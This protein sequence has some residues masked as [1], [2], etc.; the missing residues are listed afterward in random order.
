MK[1]ELKQLSRWHALSKPEVSNFE[2]QNLYRKK[3]IPEEYEEL[4]NALTV[5][6][7]I[8]EAADLIVVAAGL[9]EAHGMNV[10]DVLR[11]TN[12][13]NFSKFV[14]EENLDDEIRTFESEGIKVFSRF[15]EPGL[16]AIHRS[17]DGKILKPKKYF[18][19]DEEMLESLAMP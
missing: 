1:D 7:E 3:L 8:K 18:P 12:E 13:S 11:L 19:V 16:F 5:G 15:V 6:N 9:I 10:G 14:H 4:K 2:L 17:S